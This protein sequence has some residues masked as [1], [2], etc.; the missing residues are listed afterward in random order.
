MIEEQENI[1]QLDINTLLPTTVL[2]LCGCGRALE[3]AIDSHGRLRRY[4]VGH[5]RRKKIREIIRI[6]IDKVKTLEEAKAIIYTQAHI[7][8]ELQKQ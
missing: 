7:I 8:Q 2:C 5:N 4:I 1:I 3:S 6:E